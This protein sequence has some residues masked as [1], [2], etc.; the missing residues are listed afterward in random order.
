MNWLYL[1]AAI[2]FEVV[3]T[4]A[5]KATDGFTQWKPSLLVIVGYALAFFFLSLTLRSMP[6]GVVYAIWSGV[7]V[8]LVSIAGWFF[9]KQSLDIAAVIG[10]SL[11]L[12]GVLVL[13][14]FSKVASH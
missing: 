2:L 12:A 8:V 14:L 11:I 7:G 3:A 6:V 10:I 5:L 9:Y 1:A 13:H 4:S